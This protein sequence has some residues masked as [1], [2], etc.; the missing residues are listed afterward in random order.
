MSAE[1]LLSRLDGA[2]RTGIDRWVAKCPSHDDGRP[3]LGIR[4]LDDRRVLV[5]CW[6][7]CA[8]ADV[9]AAV[10]LGFADLFPERAFDHHLRR[11]R[12]PFNAADVLRCTAYEALIAAVAAGNLAKGLTL[13]EQD[14]DRLTLAASRLQSAAEMAHA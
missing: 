2:R 8:V 9:L 5:H 6:A 1:T 3:S 11:D 12:R 13:S 14:L 7:G 4:E 10:G